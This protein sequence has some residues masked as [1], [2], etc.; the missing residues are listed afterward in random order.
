MYNMD[1]FYLTFLKKLVIFDCACLCTI[2]LLLV[3]E[4]DS[5]GTFFI[6]STLEFSFSSFISTFIKGISGSIS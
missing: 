4:G 3:L 2:S 5:A 1:K 6:S